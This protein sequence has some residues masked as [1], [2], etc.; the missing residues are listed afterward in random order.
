[1]YFRQEIFIF[2][3]DKLSP[4]YTYEFEKADEIWLTNTSG[5]KINALHFKTDTPKG[6]I[7]YFHGNAGALDKWGNVAEDFTSKNYDVFIIDYPGYGKS[8]GR[9]SEKKLF[10][11]ALIA[12]NYID[13]NYKANEIIIYGRSI[14]TGIATELASKVKAKLLILEAPF[15]R[16]DDLIGEWMRFLPNNILLRYPLR[17][18]LHV[19]EVDFPIWVFHGTADKVVPLKSGL[20]LEK[21][22]QNDHYII[23]Q[24]GGHNDLNQYEEYHDSLKRILN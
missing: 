21:Y 10:E 2:R 24:N 5:E 18:D 9:I 16:L 20:K 7:L 15:F 6:V 13:R 4:D 22:L 3:P 8:E 11:N 1:M 19:Q 14:G 23:I 17:N 12:Y